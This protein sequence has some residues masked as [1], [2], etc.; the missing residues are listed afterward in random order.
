MCM[1]RASGRTF[2]V[3]RFLAGSRLKPTSVYRRGEPRSRL[4]P[5][6]PK[7]RSSGFGVSVSD[8]A[9]SKL[10]CQVADALRFLR[11]NRA[12]LRR[13]A[14]F[15]GVE[16]LEMDFPLDLRIGPEI[17]VQ[18]DLFPAAFVREAGRIGLGLAFTTY[19]AP[20]P[21]VDGKERT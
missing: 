15:K 8:A 6:G 7:N 12:E 16:S 20:N 11:K 18:G 17:A 9:W 13:L 5:R 10:D 19:P 3:D 1:L 14:K 2:R 21:R 4:R